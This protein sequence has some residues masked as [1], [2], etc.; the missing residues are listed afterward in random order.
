MKLKYF[1][2]GIFC[3]FF[4][5]S[6]KVL[7]NS[8]AEKVTALDDCQKISLEKNCVIIHTQIE[9]KDQPMMLDLGA[10]GGLIY[11]TAV[12]PDYYKRSKATFGTAKG[13]DRKKINSAMTPLKIHNKLHSSDN[14]VFNVLSKPPQERSSCSSAPQYIGLYGYD[15]MRAHETGYLLDFETG[16]VCNLKPA[17]LAATIDQGYRAVKA[18]VT[19]TQITIYVMI[20]GTEYTFKFDTGYYG[21]FTI[22]YDKDKIGFLND[23]HTSTEGMLGKTVSGIVTGKERTY[24]K[25]ITF[26]SKEYT[27]EITVSD[28]IKAQNVGM[29][30]IKAFNWIVDNKNKKLYIKKNSIAQDSVT[31]IAHE[32]YAFENVGKLFVMQRRVGSNDFE[33]GDEITKVNDEEVTSSNICAM[34]KLLNGNENWKTLKVKTRKP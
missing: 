2:T 3:L 18:K 24:D 32:Y 6:C 21:S 7:R 11:D 19:Y 30:F 29:G 25:K 20:D 15:L 34:W 9:G 33:V 14:K 5:Q 1:A 28:V 16:Q 22:P 17:E 10:S 26:G 27:T 13:A 31:E 4:F 23:A 12:I 8:F